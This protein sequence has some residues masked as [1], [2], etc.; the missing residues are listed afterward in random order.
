LEEET[1]GREVGGSCGAE[2]GGTAEE[3]SEGGERE[4][5]SRPPS[6]RGVAGESSVGE[7]GE[8][9]DE[10]VEDEGVSTAAEPTTA[11][12]RELRIEENMDRR[13]GGRGGVHREDERR[14]VCR[15]RSIS[16][17]GS[18]EIWSEVASV[19]DG[20]VIVLKSS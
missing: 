6:S 20:V 12:V 18:S 1:E 2:E 7:E 10:G 8:E 13:R 9:G 14:G 3:A 19:Y 11:F 16:P 15:E 17:Q 5:F 4:R